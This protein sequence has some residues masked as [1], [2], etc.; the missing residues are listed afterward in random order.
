MYIYVLNHLAE[1]WFLLGLMQCTAAYYCIRPR[2]NQ[3]SAKWF[4]L[5]SPICIDFL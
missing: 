2:R 3:H 5:Y 1:C 4:S